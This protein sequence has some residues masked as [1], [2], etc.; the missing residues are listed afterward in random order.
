MI[1]KELYNR[2][3]RHDNTPPLIVL[4]IT[5][6]IVTTLLFT[7]VSPT[8][9]FFSIALAG[10]ILHNVYVIR[11]NRDEWTRNNIIVYAVGWVGIIG[12]FII[13]RYM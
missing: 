10:L 11:R 9:W 6:Y 5:N 7:M 3:R 2:R 8:G 12:L 13:T 4:T 1:P